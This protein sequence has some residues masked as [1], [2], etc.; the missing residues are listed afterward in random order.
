MQFGRGI[1][2]PVFTPDGDD[3][4]FG[5]DG[6]HAHR[7]FNFKET[8]PLEEVTRKVKKLR[9]ARQIISQVRQALLFG[10]GL[11]LAGDALDVGA[12]AGINLDYVALFYK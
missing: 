6:R 8:L 9:P 2:V 7:G 10:H 5:R 1:Q 4:G 11:F 3:A 12:G